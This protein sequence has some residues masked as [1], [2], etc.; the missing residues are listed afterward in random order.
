MPSSRRVASRY[1]QQERQ[2]YLALP[3][4]RSSFGFEGAGADA[5]AQAMVL[6]VKQSMGVTK[7]QAYGLW[8]A[9]ANEVLRHA[10]VDSDPRLTRTG[11]SD[12]LR[13][14]YLNLADEV[15]D[16]FDAL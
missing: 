16:F 11:A 1:L 6:L 12:G 4:V 14:L 8:R 13:Y 2:A 15:T 9:I 5:A 10:D 7:K 3:P